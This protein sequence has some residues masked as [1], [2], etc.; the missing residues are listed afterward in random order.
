MNTRDAIKLAVLFLSSYVLLY[1]LPAVSKALFPSAALHEW[2]FTLN[3]S[4]LD[5]TFYLMPFVGFFFIYLLIDWINDFFQ[6]KFA[7]TV[8]FPLLFVVL[9]FVA[10][11]VQ[12]YWYYSNIVALAKAAGQNLVLNL[13]LDSGCQPVISLV[14]G[15]R[16]YNVCFWNTLREDAFLVFVFA[17][18]LGWASYKIMEKVSEKALEEKMKRKR[19]QTK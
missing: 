5:Y 13:S 14:N 15:V 1:F 2:G 16:T 18:L 19:E 4:M 3:P 12:L 11:Y 10:F 8:F 7:S 9:S 17:G 6:T